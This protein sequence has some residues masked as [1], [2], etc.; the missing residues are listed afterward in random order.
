MSDKKA[1]YLAA[2]KKY[3]RQLKIKRLQ[4][5]R[6]PRF[7]ILK[8]R[9]TLYVKYQC[10]ERS[11]FQCSGK[12]S[13]HTPRTG[14]SVPSLKCHG[15][16]GNNEMHEVHAVRRVMGWFLNTSYSHPMRRCWVTPGL[17]HLIQYNWN[18]MPK[19]FI[20]DSYL[21]GVILES[22]RKSLKYQAQSDSWMLQMA[23]A[24]NGGHILA[25]STFR[26]YNKIFYL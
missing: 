5:W 7:V 9:R 22:L 20:P 23:T 3:L 25:S 12:I 2:G 11:K 1:S 19:Y 15:D 14:F 18:T 6:T 16:A 24:I 21:L 10:L 4:L 26:S 13:P 17:K 8:M